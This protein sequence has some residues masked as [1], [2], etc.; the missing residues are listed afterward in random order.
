MKAGTKLTVLMNSQI[1]HYKST[2]PSSSHFRRQRST[3]DLPV[4]L[5]WHDADRLK[6]NFDAHS[7]RL[8]PL[9]AELLQSSQERIIILLHEKRSAFNLDNRGYMLGAL[10]TALL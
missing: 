2:A 9:A 1:F 6:E 7:Q 3:L 10:H 5:S 4:H 8:A